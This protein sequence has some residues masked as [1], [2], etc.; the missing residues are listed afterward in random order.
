MPVSRFIGLSPKVVESPQLLQARYVRDEI[1]IEE[2]ETG[3]ELELAL[4]Q[5]RDAPSPYVRSRVSPNSIG[6]SRTSVTLYGAAA[7]AAFMSGGVIAFELT[8]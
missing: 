2:L 5:Y 7:L 4:P 8:T 3:L 6:R 1:S